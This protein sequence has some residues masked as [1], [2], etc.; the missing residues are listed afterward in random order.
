MVSKVA[1]ARKSTH[2]KGKSTGKT[3]GK[4]I[5][6]DP[7]KEFEI[8]EVGPLYILWGK[9]KV[10]T[11]KGKTVKKYYIRKDEK[12]LVW[13][14]W[15][16][17]F[18]DNKNIYWS[19]EPQSILRESGLEVDVDK[20]IRQKKIWPFPSVADGE[21][22]GYAERLNICKSAKYQLWQSAKKGEKGA[23]WTLL[24]GVE[25]TTASSDASTSETSETE[26]SAVEEE[27]E[28]DDEV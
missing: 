2:S 7:N 14:Q 4:I 1:K 24:N 15:S 27:E 13:V 9:K 22:S 5:R 3:R 12:H 11:E 8:E 18:A 21:D 28:E 17:G 16:K 19:A 26:T 6:D 20:A 10:R 25:A 23:A